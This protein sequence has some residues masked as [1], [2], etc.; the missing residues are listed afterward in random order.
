MTTSFDLGFNKRFGLKRN[1]LQGDIK[2]DFD[3]ESGY[4]FN[5]LT[6]YH[7]D[8]TQTNLDLLYRDSHDLPNPVQAVFPGTLPYTNFT[9]VVAS[10]TYDWSQELRVSSPAKESFR[11]TAGAN[12][13]D[14]H[15]PAGGTLSNTNI[16]RFAAGE[17]IH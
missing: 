15:N 13:I 5:S 1:A 12:Y 8:K 11:W 6:A 14:V 7:K 4:N 16:G 9:T 2:A 17:F 3:M 10:R